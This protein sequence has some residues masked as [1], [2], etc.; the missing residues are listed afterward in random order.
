MILDRIENLPLCEGLIPGAG[1]IAK[2][3]R[4]GRAQDAPYEVREKAYATKDDADRLFEVHGRTIDLMIARSGAEVIH[5]CPEAGMERIRPLP[6]GADG[7]KL[8]SP[9][10]G[11]AALLSE[12]MFCAIFPGEAHMVAGRAGGKDGR[13]EKWVVKVPAAPEL[14]AG[15]PGPA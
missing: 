13:V 7:Y 1:R 4:D 6:D 12:G 3:F 8:A 14:C 2:A 11:T 10:R 9:P 5:I 15:D